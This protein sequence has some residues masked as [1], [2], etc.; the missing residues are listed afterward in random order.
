MRRILL[1]SL[2]IALLASACAGASTPDAM[3]KPTDAMMDES[4]ETAMPE[5]TDEAMA[6]PTD[7]ASDDAATAQ[8]PA[9]LDTELHDVNSGQTF[10]LS[11]FHGQVVLVEAMAVWCINCKRE[12]QELVQLH[13]QIG[14]AATS[15]AIDI[16]LNEDEALLKRHA[17]SNG[18]DWRYAVASPEL[19]QALADQFG[20]QVLNPP[21][22]PMFLIDKDGG[23]HLL[24]F[25]HKSVAYLT[26]Q[27]QSY[28]N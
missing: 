17:E 20:N 6:H 10:K 5:P 25:G 9:W 8:G 19:V 24:D 14:D 11:D 15:V 1:F 22:V 13:A 7:M 21:S 18:F 12:Q 2:L 3:S 26:Q 16:D 27:I 23:V 28:Q 4:V